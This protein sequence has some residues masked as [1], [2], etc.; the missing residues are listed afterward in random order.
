MCL[1]S[2]PGQRVVCGG[3][4]EGSRHVWTVGLLKCADF[5][6]GEVDVERCHDIGEVVRRDLDRLEQVITGPTARS[7]C[8]QFQAAISCEDG[9]VG[10]IDGSDE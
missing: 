9:S 1:N 7:L 2:P 3:L 10:D 6:V 4:P 5:I 8:A